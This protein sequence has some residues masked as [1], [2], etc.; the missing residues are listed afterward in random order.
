MTA[1]FPFAFWIEGQRIAGLAF[2]TAP[3]GRPAIAVKLFDDSRLLAYADED[4][5]IGVTL[6]W[7]PPPRKRE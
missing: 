5:P 3:N 1:D 4:N 7:V 2:E 6:T